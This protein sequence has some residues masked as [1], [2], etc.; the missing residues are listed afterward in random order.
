MGMESIWKVTIIASIFIMIILLVPL[1]PSSL[2]ASCP[3]S[4]TQVDASESPEHDE[5]QNGLIC[6]Y[7]RQAT[8][9]P[10]VTIYQDDMV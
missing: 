2:A 5:N 3:A 7:V 1:I 6:Q 4:M 8:G 9:F 10:T